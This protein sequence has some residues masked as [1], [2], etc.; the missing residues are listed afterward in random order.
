MLWALRARPAGCLAR[1]GPTRTLAHG[2]GSTSVLTGARGFARGLASDL[3]SDLA[4]LG[5][6]GDATAVRRCDVRSGV[7]ANATFDVWAGLDRMV[8][9]AAPVPAGRV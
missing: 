6:P 4:T 7:G 1:P 3:A 8:W 9:E 5:Q 2:R